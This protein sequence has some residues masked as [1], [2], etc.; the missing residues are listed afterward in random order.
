MS[1]KGSLGEGRYEETG[2][3]LGQGYYAA[4]GSIHDDPTRDT[5]D[6]AAADNCYEEGE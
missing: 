2:R 4:P 5:V 1:E 3:T 6:D